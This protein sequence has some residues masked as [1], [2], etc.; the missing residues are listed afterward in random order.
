VQPTTNKHLMAALTKALKTE[1][2][3]EKPG[4]RT[5]GCFPQLRLIQAGGRERIQLWDL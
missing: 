1:E 5:V 4:G 2:S 3:T